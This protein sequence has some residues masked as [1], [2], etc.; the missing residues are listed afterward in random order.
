[1]RAIYF[2]WAGMGDIKRPEADVQFGVSS[3]QL[4]H[5]SGRGGARVVFFV[6]VTGQGADLAPN[7]GYKV[8]CCARVGCAF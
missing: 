8:A 2:H 5:N 1:M 4:F 6:L 3:Y 7:A